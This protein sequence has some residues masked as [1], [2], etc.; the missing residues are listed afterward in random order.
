[1][2][3]VPGLI[4]APASRIGA[5]AQ[6]ALEVARFGGLETDEQPSPYEIVA[7]RP[8]FRLR[9]YYPP[10]ESA[11]RGPHVPAVLLVPP[12]MLAAEIYD[13]APS[14][15]AVS[16]LHEN[17][18]EPWVV[19]FG[20]PEKEEG[21]LERSLTDH[22]LAVSE[23]IDLVAEETARDVHIGGYSQGGMFCY[24]VA[25]YRRSESIASV[26]VFGSPVDTRGTLSFGLPE[27]L[28]TRGAAFFA[29]NLLARY[30]LPAWASRTGFRLMDP[31]KSLR[32]RLQ[33]LRHIHDREALLPRERQRRF[34]EADGW[35]AWP[36]PALAEVIKQFGVH[37]RMVSGAEPRS[38]DD[39]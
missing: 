38:V 33:F 21:G 24:Q 17:G 23:A 35:V 18:V 34:L 29:D 12:M 39:G 1:M 7:E 25:A 16:I 30:A 8:V 4:T 9:R 6:N 22:V 10:S 3:L 37:N 15:S 28:L 11:K 5:A 36:G 2:P 31:A 14:T 26:I 20:A 19:D 13:V 32:Q 27:E